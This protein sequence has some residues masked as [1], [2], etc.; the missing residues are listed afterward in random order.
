MNNLLCIVG[1]T[2]VGKTRLAEEIRKSFDFAPH[3]SVQDPAQND[4]NPIGNVD[5]I[6]I[7]SRQVYIG[8]N[9]GTGKDAKILGTDLVAPKSLFSVAEFV[10]IVTPMIEKIW[11][12]SKL[13]IL[14]GGTGFYLKAIIDG[15]ETIEIPPNNKLRKELEKYSVP[16]LQEKLLSMYP[17]IYKL[18]GKRRKI[19]VEEKISEQAGMNNSD[20]NNPRRLIRKIEI[21]YYSSVGEHLPVLPMG[22]TGR[23]S[24]TLKINKTLIIGLTAPLPI[25]KQNIEHRVQERLDNG[26]LEEIN[27]LVKK[28]GWNEVL[29]NTIAYREWEDFFAKKVTRDKTITK[30]TQDE[31]DYAKRQLT[32]FKKDQRVMWLTDNFLERTLELIQSTHLLD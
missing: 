7:D 24:P 16:R 13:P 12:N 20:W 15:I 18:K 32:W 19:K 9:I 14:V 25:I 1:P 27:G 8:M 26:L 6:S 21:L 17:Y 30:W 23:S 10:R 28:Y 2:G 29:R 3:H 5:L 31:F 4:Q 22:T 11:E